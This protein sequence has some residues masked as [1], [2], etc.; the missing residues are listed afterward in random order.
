MP[1]CANISVPVLKRKRINE[2]IKKLGPVCLV[3]LTLI[4]TLGLYM[5]CESVVRTN[6]VIPLRRDAKDY[7]FYAY[8]LR[9]KDT[10]SRTAVD[11]DNPTAPVPPDSVRSPGYPLFLLPFVDGPPTRQMLTE[12]ALAQAIL[13]TLTILFAFLLYLAFLPRSGA[14]LASLLT[15]LSPHLIA[16]NSYVLTE[17]LFSFLVVVSAWSLTHLM[18]NP[19]PVR[20]GVAGISIGIAALV[21]PAMQFLPFAAFI[22]LLHSCRRRDGL[23]LGAY[24]L[25]GFILTLSPWL[26]R[27]VSVHSTSNDN[28]LMA[29][30]LHHGIYPEFMYENNPDTKPFPHRVDPRTPEIEGNARAILEEILTRCIDHPGLYLKWYLVGKP[31]AFWSWNTV[32]GWRDVFTYAVAETPYHDDELFKW[33]HTLMYGFH[34]PLVVLCLL[35]SLLAWNP[36]AMK[37]FDPRT[38]SMA[39]LLSCYILYF[40]VLHMIGAPFP[41]YAFPLRPLQFGMAVFTVVLA[42]RHLRGR[43]PRSS[44]AL[45]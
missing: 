8:N 3:A 45:S 1:G 23:R 29:D 35:G 16:G 19:S 38:A 34:W 2:M 22:P 40:T 44:E 42:Y 11:P 20:A 17:S 12:I 36:R 15:A 32:Q 30:F 6:V 5:R 43:L 25:L 28:S 21:R 39:R 33:T 31:I 7:F 24:M 41:R 37:S 10:Y 13:S 26:I 9:F 18:A 14:L 27:N 4:T